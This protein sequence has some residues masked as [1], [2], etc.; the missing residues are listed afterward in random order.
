MH[1]RRAGICEAN[2][3]AGGNQ[4]AQKALSSVHGSR[5]YVSSGRAGQG[6]V[7]ANLHSAAAMSWWRG[8]A[9]R[10]P[11]RA[12]V[13]PGF[14]SIMARF[15]GTGWQGPVVVEIEVVC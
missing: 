12:C 6:I 3:Y 2:V 5:L 13:D 9:L 10:S 8:V 14:I 7:S 11:P 15:A 1:L 4:R